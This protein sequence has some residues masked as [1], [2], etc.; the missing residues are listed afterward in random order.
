MV[1]AGQS[2]APATA[3]HA[4]PVRP[5]VPTRWIELLGRSGFSFLAFPNFCL[6][7]ENAALISVIN[8]VIRSLDLIN[9]LWPFR[10]RRRLLFI[11]FGA[12]PEGR[13]LPS[14]PY[15]P[16]LPNSLPTQPTSQLQTGD[17]LVLLVC[18]GQGK[19]KAQKACR[20]FNWDPGTPGVKKV[21]LRHYWQQL[22][23]TWSFHHLPPELLHTL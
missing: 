1:P 22:P 7:P 17:K 12:P 14:Q 13:I 6:P 21:S 20:I 9:L 19:I 11:Y 15:Q 18:G 2:P 10:A 16:E 3:T 4:V 8:P 5:P 23:R